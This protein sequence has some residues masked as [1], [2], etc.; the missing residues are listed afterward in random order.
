MNVARLRAMRATTA[1][2]GQQEAQERTKVQRKENAQNSKW[3]R[4]QTQQ[5]TLAQ[6]ATEPCQWVPTLSAAARI[7]EI[8]DHHRPVDQGPTLEAARPMGDNPMVPQ[9]VY[10]QDGMS[11]L[12]DTQWSPACTHMAMLDEE[13]ERLASGARTHTYIR[14][15]TGHQRAHT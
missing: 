3:E 15:T 12:A 8:T 10:E 1:A 11:G 9:E 7:N 2:T 6:V 14:T 13:D 5:H 4:Q